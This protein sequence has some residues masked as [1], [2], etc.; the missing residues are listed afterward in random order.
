MINC[1]QYYQWIRPAAEGGTQNIFIESAFATAQGEIAVRISSTISLLRCSISWEG[2]QP[3][4]AR[5]QK[6]FEIL[7]EDTLAKGGNVSQR[8]RGNLGRYRAGRISKSY[9]SAISA[10]GQVRFVTTLPGNYWK[11]YHCCFSQYNLWIKFSCKS[12][13]F[14]L[15]ISWMTRFYRNLESWT[16]FCF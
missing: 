8:T 6:S 1:S 3:Y 9:R 14:L 4:R 10:I 15:R 2:S 7:A 12:M 13:L 16:I 5:Y 11:K